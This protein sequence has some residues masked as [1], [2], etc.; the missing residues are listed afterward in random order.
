M[1]R[2]RDFRHKSQ[3]RSNAVLW[4]VVALA[5]A[6]TA[7]VV[8]D[9]IAKL[10]IG[11]DWS[12]SAG[13]PN[14]ARPVFEDLR[15]EWKVLADT[16]KAEQKAASA[17]SDTGS[18]W[19]HRDD[20]AYRILQSVAS[21]LEALRRAEARRESTQWELDRLRGDRREWD[22]FVTG[23]APERPRHRSGR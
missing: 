1:R 14:S 3:A 6:G 18:F 16:W 8:Q 13:S 17:A 2:S 5:V 7:V 21:H 15:D 10:P 23:V 22:A 20:D 12:P 4:V 9:R 11:A 19:T